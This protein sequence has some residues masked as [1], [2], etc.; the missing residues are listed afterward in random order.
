MAFTLQS[1]GLEQAKK[2]TKT[3]NDSFNS[4]DFEFY[5]ALKILGKNPILK[6]FK[7]YTIKKHRV[8]LKEESEYYLVLRILHQSMDTKRH[9]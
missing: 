3:I 7:Y 6:Q 2:Y 5:T 1:W 8:I 4:I 9:L